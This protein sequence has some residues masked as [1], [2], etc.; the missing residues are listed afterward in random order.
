MGAAA[1]KSSSISASSI[2]SATF[3]LNNKVEWTQVLHELRQ[4]W[5][6]VSKSVRF[7]NKRSVTLSYII[8]EQVYNSFLTLTKQQV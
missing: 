1:I 5:M 4:F 2:A 7:S 6:V 3:S 8:D